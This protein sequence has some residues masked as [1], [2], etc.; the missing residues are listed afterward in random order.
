MKKYITIGTA[1]L[2]GTLAATEARTYRSTD[3]Y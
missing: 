3:D 2:I 1:A